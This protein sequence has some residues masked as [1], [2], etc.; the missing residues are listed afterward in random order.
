MRSKVDVI[1]SRIMLISHF[2]IADWLVVAS[3]WPGDWE[4]SVRTG[5][6]QLLTI[7]ARGKFDII[8][9]GKVRGA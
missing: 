6:Q 8:L 3:C 2:V 9:Y 5:K 4:R 1:Y 7:L